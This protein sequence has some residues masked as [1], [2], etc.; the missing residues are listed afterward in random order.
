[1][2]KYEISSNASSCYSEVSVSINGEECLL[3]TAVDDIF[4]QIQEHVNLMHCELRNLCMSEERNDDYTEALEYYDA[5][6]GNIREGCTVFKQLIPISKQLLPKKPK[7][8]V[9]PKKALGAVAEES[10]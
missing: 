7:G 9:N 10:K 8:W 2:D 5:L 3:E 1:M 6:V 4:K